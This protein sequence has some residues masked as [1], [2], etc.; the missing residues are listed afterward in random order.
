MKNRKK[1]LKLQAKRKITT[2]IIQ[3]VGQIVFYKIKC[4]YISL[5]D[6]FVCEL[7]CVIQNKRLAIKG[8]INPEKL[9]DDGILLEAPPYLR[10]DK[11]N[12]TEINLSKKDAPN[13]YKLLQTYVYNIGDRLDNNLPHTIDFNFE[14]KIG[15][16]D[17][18]LKAERENFLNVNKI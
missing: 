7:Y 18:Q 8:I 1:L 16:N 9:V 12:C 13:F 10:S 15:V 11:Y 6:D 17:V 4:H 3:N 2:N 5:T 14:N